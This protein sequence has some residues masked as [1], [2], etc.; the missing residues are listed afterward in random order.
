[1]K[2][3]YISCILKGLVFFSSYKEASYLKSFEFAALEKNHRLSRG[4]KLL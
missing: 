1:M 2:K 3:R 4:V